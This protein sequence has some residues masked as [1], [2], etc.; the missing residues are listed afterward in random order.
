MARIVR[1]VLFSSLIACH[2]SVSLCGPCFHGLQLSA[3]HQMGEVSTP[4]RPDHPILP[5]SDSRDSCL[6]CQFVAQSQLPVEFSQERLPQ[7]IIELVYSTLPSS[8]PVANPLAACPRA[9]PNGLSRAF[10]IG[11]ALLTA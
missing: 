10:L 7:L 11:G 6:V 4:Y 3:H 2:A 1:Q 8:Q 5:G 9:P